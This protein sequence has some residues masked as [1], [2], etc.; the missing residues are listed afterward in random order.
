MNF[1][2]LLRVK[3]VNE[4]SIVFS[5]SPV[6]VRC[7]SP[8]SLPTDPAGTLQAQFALTLATEGLGVGCAAEA[9]LCQGTVDADRPAE[10]VHRAQL[11]EGVQLTV[12]V[13]RETLGVRVEVRLEDGACFEIE[14]QGDPSCPLLH[15]VL[16][17][18]PEAP[19]S[20]LASRIGK[21]IIRDILS[22]PADWESLGW[23]SVNFAACEEPSPDG[24]AEGRRAHR[25]LDQKVL[26]SPQDV[27]LVHVNELRGWALVVGKYSYGSSCHY[28]IEFI[29]A[30][31]REG[32]FS[33]SATSI[34]A[35]VD[36]LSFDSL[37]GR[38]EAEQR[39]E[40]M[41]G[42]EQ[43]FARA[44]EVLSRSAQ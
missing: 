19:Q 3:F 21:A 23:C 37:G 29:C 44:F 34:S 8:A 22:A 13:G 42:V 5:M 14:S 11:F 27:L 20:R 18:L 30:G 2:P 26:V 25:V 7:K 35:D 10:R 15:D 41:H 32:E 28:E 9:V 38:Q 33:D 16:R 12:A 1:S 4:F 43:Q 36:E 31:L 24:E 6:A 40:R 39:L 17:A